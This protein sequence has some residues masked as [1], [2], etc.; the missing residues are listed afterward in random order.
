MAF[1]MLDSGRLNR[2]QPSV[3]TPGRT[4]ETAVS[5]IM[6][7]SSNLNLQCHTAPCQTLKMSLIKRMD[8]LRDYS[9]TKQQVHNIDTHSLLGHFLDVTTSL[10]K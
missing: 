9:V 8:A 6:H 3:V 10:T 1:W 5:T 7:I 2:K 4:E